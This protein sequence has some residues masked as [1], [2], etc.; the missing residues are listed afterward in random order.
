MPKI[1][2][3]IPVYNQ[4]LYLK[5]CLDSVINQTLK[6]IEIICIDDCSTDNSL[7]ILKK[8]NQKDNRI[9]II[10][11][12]NN[13][14][15]GMVRNIGIDISAGEYIMFVDPDDYIKLN[16]CEI[17]Y[18]NARYYNSDFVEFL[19]D[20]FDL[21]NKNLNIKKRYN[22]PENELINKDIIIKN[23]I[24]SPP[25]M[26][27]N[28]FYKSEFLK[29]NKI[30][31]YNG[32][33][34]EDH[35]VTIKTRCLA[36]RITAVN[37]V[38][39]HYRINLV[40]NQE[41]N[42]KDIIPILKEIKSFL[43][44]K[45]FL[46]DIYP[47]WYNYYNNMLFMNKNKNKKNGLFSVI[48]NFYERLHN[49][50]YNKIISLGYN[51]QVAFALSS[52][53]GA[54]SLESNLFNWVYVEDINKLLQYL[55]KPELLLSK[56]LIFNKDDYMYTDVALGFRYHTKK[57]HKDFYNE[58]N[59]LNNNFIIQDKKDVS[60]R[61]YYLAG[62]FHSILS[63][64]SKNLFI[65]CFKSNVEYEK[66]PEIIEKLSNYFNQNCGNKNSKVLC[67]FEEEYYK[68]LSL[69]AYNNIIYT[70]ISEFP[71]DAYADC[72]D[73]DEW[74]NITKNI[75]LIKRKSIIQKIFSV[76]NEYSSCTKHKVITFLGIKVKFSARTADCK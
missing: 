28:K 60:S 66:V 52:I 49:G 15:T 68:H 47:N 29:T 12:K 42:N 39:Y 45:G 67:I 56:G 31:F 44:C 20:R 55:Y 74:R 36:E 30:Y 58:N 70:S 38:L 53:Y 26:A 16:A 33:F 22:L 14:G 48:K 51:C 57:N 4:E 3:I 5:D 72:I 76:T 71:P 41:N 25:I 75:I 64:K 37:S 9:K 2:I 61:I 32:R 65:L 43:V 7:S 18:N 63:S 54:D 1:S 27:W 46:S 8:Y 40:N 17:L 13:I 19:F 34:A 23:N 10:A 69:N 59:T 73:I 11:Q 24:F 6:D 21:N 50:M 62:K 35:I